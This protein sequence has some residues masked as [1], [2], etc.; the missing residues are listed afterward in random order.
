MPRENLIALIEN[1]VWACAIGL[2]LIAFP[3]PSANA[4]EPPRKECVAVSKQ[5]YQSAKRQKL[6]QT[7]FSKYVRTG[8]LGRRSYWYCHS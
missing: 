7:R 4:E 2:V 1:P 3:S 8:R 5:E 6:L